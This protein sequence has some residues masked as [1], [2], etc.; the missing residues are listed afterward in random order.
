MGDDLRELIER[1]GRGGIGAEGMALLV[2]MM[3]ST[4]FSLDGQSFLMGALLGPSMPRSVLIPFALSLSQNTASMQ[5][6]GGT[7][8]GPMGN[9]LFPF[10]LLSLLNCEGADSG[11]KIQVIEKTPQRGGGRA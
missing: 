5:G 4:G 3:S 11:E 7:T 1:Y 9:N 8:T 10:L 2:T 6:T